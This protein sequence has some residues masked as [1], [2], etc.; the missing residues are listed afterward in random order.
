[1]IDTI[2]L[3]LSKNMFF[4]TDVDKFQKAKQNAS[5]GYFTLVQNPTKNEKQY[6]PR[7]TLT[8]RFNTS[9]QFEQTLAIELSLPKLIY[10]NNFDEL[11][12]EDYEM[13]K[14][15]LIERLE[16]MGVK[17][18]SYMFD[19]FP[20]STI[21]YSKNFVLK[22]GTTSHFLI[23][24]I[25]ESDVKKSLDVNQTDYRNNGSSYKIHCNSY[26]ITFYDKL[27]DL[28]KAGISFKRTIERDSYC[29][30]N[31]F[32]DKNI[33]FEVL[34]MEVRLNNRQ[35]IKQIFRKLNIESN[36]GFKSLFNNQ[37]SKQILTY[38]W[39]EIQNKRPKIYDY[40]IKDYKT[41]LMDIRFNNQN[42]TVNKLI[43]IFGI[44]Q[45][46][47]VMNIRELKTVFPKKSYKG[48]Y[49]LMNEI[50]KIDLPIN[51]SPLLKITN[52]LGKFKPTRL[53]DFNT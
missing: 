16:K 27:K 37:I 5:R 30:L 40:K 35:K 36:F 28:E 21:H 11:V 23:E 32:K 47:E 4:I 31:L 42:I 15:L 29:Q 41:F 1:M 38:Y 46:L 20:I 18:Y 43:K 51:Y 39:N 24:K 49:R 45:L 10:G 12:N 7:L 14:K 50:N 9:K 25:R 33:F 2:K 48:W 26:E 17:I 22:D 52:L 13:V 8:K 3:V 19:D 6:Q 53:V 44:K 34:R